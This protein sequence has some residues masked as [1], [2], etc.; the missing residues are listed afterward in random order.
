MLEFLKHALG[1]C[2]ESHPNLI[3]ILLGTPAIGYL[4][5]RLREFKSKNLQ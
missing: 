5:Y 3:T 2:G 4:A 1:L